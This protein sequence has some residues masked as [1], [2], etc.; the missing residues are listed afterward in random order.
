LEYG[1][2]YGRVKAE[3][4]LRHLLYNLQTIRRYLPADVK[5]MAAVKADAYG[6]GAPEI[7]KTLTVGGVDA[8]GAAICEEGIQLRE[9]GIKT[10]VL[11]M[12]FTPEPLMKEAM[13]HKLIQ[14]VFSV[15]TAKAFARAAAE[16]E[17]KAEVHIKIDT[18]MG[19]LGFLPETASIDRI[20]EI[21][22]MR[23]LRVSGIY[24]HLATSDALDNSFMHE[25]R[26]R[27]EWVLGKLAERGLRIPLT[28]ISNSGAFAQT[29][30]GAP[31]A[32]GGYFR[33]MIRI[34]ILLYGLLPSGE[35]RGVC[36]TLGIKP[37]MR[38][39]TQVGMVKQLPSGAGISYGHMFRTERETRVATLP[40]GYAD[41]Y[42]RR[43]S[44]KAH[45]LIRGCKAPVV[46]AIC[47]DQCMAD[48][49]DIPGEVKPG[50]EAVLL[51]SQGNEEISADDLADIVGTIGYEI[52]CG[53][54]KRVPRV[55]I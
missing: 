37:V 46:G 3:I 14:T 22:A 5:L 40:V 51:G 30:R 21:A 32:D 44:N 11:I 45:V 29:L 15:E 41:G 49:T 18:G 28:H 24:T 19:R 7:A 42:P 27:F 9:N 10:P 33:D 52:V 1:K 43:L 47:M 23:T 20:C 13:N 54:G 4:N 50:D 6:H 31:Y 26:T 39:I 8:L 55:Y 34:G 36:K 25:Q 2:V 38:L 17:T 35:M 53:I 12:G 48:V 16:L